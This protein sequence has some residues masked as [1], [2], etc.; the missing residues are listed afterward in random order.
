MAARY[1]R[2][3]AILASNQSFAEQ[4]GVYCSAVIAPTVRD[5]LIPHTVMSSTGVGRAIAWGRR[6]RGLGAAIP[7]LPARR[8]GETSLPKDNRMRVWVKSQWVPLGHNVGVGSHNGGGDTEC[9]NVQAPI[10]IVAPS[11]TN[12][13]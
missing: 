4:G 5:R 12:T 7:S 13:K 10:A 8:A 2:G 11:R 3:S 6:S 9:F 1:K